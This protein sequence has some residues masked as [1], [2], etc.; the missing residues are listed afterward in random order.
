MDEGPARR[1]RGAPALGGCLGCLGA[2]E[3]AAAGSGCRNECGRSRNARWR[4][5]GRARLAAVP[6]CGPGRRIYHGPPAAA[7]AR[8]SLLLLARP[9]P[10]PR[11]FVYRLDLF[12]EGARGASSS[13]RCTTARRWKLEATLR[14]RAPTVPSAP[15]LCLP[16][17]TQTA[18]LPRRERE[19]G[20]SGETA[21][22]PPAAP[23]LARCRRTRPGRRLDR[24]GAGVG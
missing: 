24:G 20:R 7:V 16:S 11:G 18:Q 21:P 15:G 14:V 3:G 13:G 2:G 17:R 23:G 19:A 5:A 8:K 6:R 1:P 12:S 4:V 10:E 9:Q 22:S